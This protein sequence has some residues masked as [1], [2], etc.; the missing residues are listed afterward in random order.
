MK[1]LL[2]RCN[3]EIR[4]FLKLI[5]FRFQLHLQFEKQS[6]NHVRT[7]LDVNFSY[8]AVILRWSS[9]LHHSDIFCSL[10]TSTACQ[11]ANSQLQTSDFRRFMQYETERDNHQAAGQHKFS[12]SIVNRAVN[13]NPSTAPSVPGP[14]ILRTTYVRTHLCRTTYYCTSTLCYSDNPVSLLL[15]LLAATYQCIISAKIFPFFSKTCTE[16]LVLLI[17]LFSSTKWHP[18]LE[19]QD[20]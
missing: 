14:W 16:Q 19:F 12:Q 6:S 4:V 7:V 9:F 20:M 17:G 8:G 5:A 2:D 11:S 18:C 13:P 1:C 10:V 15:Y 3:H